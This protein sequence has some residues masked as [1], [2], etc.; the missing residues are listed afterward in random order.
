MNCQYDRYLSFQFL[1]F[2]ALPLPGDVD[3]Y[4]LLLTLVQL[5][6][7]CLLE[8]LIVLEDGMYLHQ[9]EDNALAHIGVGVAEKD[10]ECLCQCQQIL[11]ELGELLLANFKTVR[12][13]IHKFLDVSEFILYH[14]EKGLESWWLLLPQKRLNGSREEV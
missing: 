9:A 2:A 5:V 11:Y 7:E 10:A 12:S 14:A 4:K 13:L 8:Q 1:L 3:I 6:G